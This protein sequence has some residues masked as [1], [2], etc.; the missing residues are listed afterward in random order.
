MGVASRSILSRV[1]LSFISLLPWSG[2]SYDCPSQLDKRKKTTVKRGETVSEGTSK[3]SRIN[4]RI[5]LIGLQREE[6]CYNVMY[7]PQWK[8]RS[9]KDNFLRAKIEDG[10]SLA[11]KWILGNVARKRGNW[12][13]ESGSVKWFHESNGSKK[14]LKYPRTS[15][16]W[17]S[18][19]ST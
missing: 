19:Q 14:E 4:D 11:R 12:W 18:S 7:A 15:S 16:I 13:E 8:S 17:K 3:K 1:V 10:E 6:L 5:M 9:V 2:G